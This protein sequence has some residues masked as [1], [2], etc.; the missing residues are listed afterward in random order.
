M[1]LHLSVI[2]FKGGVCILACIGA[3][4]PIGQTPPWAD[5]PI[6]QTPPTHADTFGRHPQADTSPG[7]H[8]PGKYPPGRHPPSPS[9]HPLPADASYWNAFLFSLLIFFHSVKLTSHLESTS[10]FSISATPRNRQIWVRILR[11]F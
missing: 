7:R 8:P 6:G 9:K 5:T 4:T 10:N 2:L 11:S 3:D 1:F